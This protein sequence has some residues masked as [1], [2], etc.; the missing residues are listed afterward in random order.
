MTIEER[1]DRIDHAVAGLAQQHLA[2]TETLREIR[3]NQ[4]TMLDNQK[5]VLAMLDTHGNRISALETASK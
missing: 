2:I 4:K 3:D 1:L 5:T